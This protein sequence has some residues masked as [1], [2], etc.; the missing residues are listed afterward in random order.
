MIDQVSRRLAKVEVPKEGEGDLAV[1]WAGAEGAEKGFY[2]SDR[3]S[4]ARLCKLAHYD[5]NITVAAVAVD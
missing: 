3:R 1:A 2:L 5:C 4:P